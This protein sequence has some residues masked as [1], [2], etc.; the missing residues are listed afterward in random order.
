MCTSSLTK[1]NEAFEN[2]LI[3]YLNSENIYPQTIELISPQAVKQL[4]IASDWNSI[5][6]LEKHE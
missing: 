4:R 6:S 5:L 3:D 2:H 1:E